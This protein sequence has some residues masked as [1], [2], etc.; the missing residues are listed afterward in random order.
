[1]KRFLP[2]IRVFYHSDYFDAEIKVDRYSKIRCGLGNPRQKITSNSAKIRAFVAKS[3]T[4]YNNS[5]ANP[6]Q[7]YQHIHAPWRWICHARKKN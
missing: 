5:S 4:A 2:R 1:V 7:K 3:L 6:R